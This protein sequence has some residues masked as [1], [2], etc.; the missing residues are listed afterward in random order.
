MSENKTWRK[1]RRYEPLSLGIMGYKDEELCPHG[2][3][4]DDGVHGCDGCCATPKEER[5]Y[6]RK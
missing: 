1:H 5:I 6:E 2:I 3:G 4:H